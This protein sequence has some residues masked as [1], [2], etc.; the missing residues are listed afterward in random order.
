MHILN[1]IK[2]KLAE[3]ILAKVLI[4]KKTPKIKTIKTVIWIKCS[5]SIHSFLARII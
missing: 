1:S 4:I 3:E 5:W 2:L